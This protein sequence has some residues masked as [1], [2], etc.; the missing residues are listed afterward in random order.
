[1]WRICGDLCSTFA[2]LQVSRGRIYCRASHTGDACRGR[3][4]ERERGIL[5]EL[6]DMTCWGS[7]AHLGAILAHLE[8]MLAYVG[9][10]WGLCWPILG[11]CWPILGLY[12]P[13]LGAM[14][15]D[16]GGYVGPSW[17]YVGPSCG[18]MLTHLETQAL[19][20]H[21]EPRKTWKP[22]NPSTLKDFRKGLKAIVLATTTER[23]RWIFELTLIVGSAGLLDPPF[24]RSVGLRAIEWGPASEIYSLGFLEHICWK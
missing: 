15:A 3:G 16:L 12:W 23:R 21:P 11:L 24:H 20:S 1:M 8:A 17:G 13:I 14:L 22:E 10:S 7:A 5:S 19:K 18:P 4:R 9:P 6:A 2:W